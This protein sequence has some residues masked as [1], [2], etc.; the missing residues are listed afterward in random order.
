MAIAFVGSLFGIYEHIEHN[1]AFALEIRP[2]AV[3]FGVLTDALRGA[4]PLLALGILALATV[5]ALSATNY[6][7]AL[8][9]RKTLRP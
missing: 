9:G 3:T 4:N 7:P 5:L 8:Q 1:M 6:H 2:N